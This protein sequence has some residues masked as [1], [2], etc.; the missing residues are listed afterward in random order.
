MRPQISA[1]GADPAF[2]ADED[3]RNGLVCDLAGGPI[4]GLAFTSANQEHGLIDCSGLSEPD[5]DRFPIGARLRILPNHA[6]ATGAQFP[7]YQAFNAKGVV[8][9]WARFNG[10]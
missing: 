8:R 5:L 3:V 2:I 10:W 4:N 9:P 7:F 6:C 1:T